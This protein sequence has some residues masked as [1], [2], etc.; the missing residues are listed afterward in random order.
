MRRRQVAERVLD[1]MQVLDQQIAARIEAG[2]EPVDAVAG[3]R[4][5]RTAARARAP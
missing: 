5:D 3:F 2:A 4:I 1:A